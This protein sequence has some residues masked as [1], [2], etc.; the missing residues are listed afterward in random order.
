MISGG[1]DP[2]RP[3]EQIL[4]LLKLSRFSRILILV[5]LCSW[6]LKSGLKTISAEQNHVGRH[7][8]LCSADWMV[9]KQLVMVVAGFCASISSWKLTI[10]HKMTGTGMCSINPRLLFVVICRRN[11]LQI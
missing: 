6:L 9:W 10:I 1:G 2:P 5:D 3:K 7:V 11:D 8:F 4:D